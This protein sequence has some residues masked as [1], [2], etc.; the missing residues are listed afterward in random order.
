MSGVE[1]V[2]IFTSALSNQVEAYI[3]KSKW[4]LPS[5]PFQVNVINNPNSASVGDVMRELDQKTLIKSDFILVS[6][7][8][9]C[10]VPLQN[11]LEGHKER[12]SANKSFIMT[13]VLRKVAPGHRTQ[14]RGE[15]TVFVTGSDTSRV[16]HYEYLKHAPTT[17][18]LAIPRELV[19]TNDSLTFQNDLLDC[20]IDIV[21]PDVPPLFTEN[22]DWQHLRKDF[23]HGILMDELYGKTVHCHI[24]EADYSSRIES[25]STYD[26]VNMDVACRWAYPFC[27]DSN[28]VSG[29]TYKYSR[30]HIYKEKDVIL[31]RSAAVQESSIVGGGSIIGEGSV[32]IGSIIGMNCKIGRNVRLCYAKIWDDVVIEDNCQIG[33]SIVANNSHIGEGCTIASG[34]IVSFGVKL[35]KGSRIGKTERLTRFI[36]QD[37][38]VA[39]WPGKFMA[40]SYRDYED[41]EDEEEE[42][43]ETALTHRR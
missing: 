10:N 17:S 2:F 25:L 18:T 19:K 7:D 28:M 37:D 29:Q 23:L 38:S 32:V 20:F 6:G 26:A 14:P 41:S 30:G 8:I 3:E 39:V 1:E 13:S 33:N 31:A 27:P 16:L 43:I 42:L 36:E 35:E 9:V 5:S 12:K 22:F 15:N 24:L 11:I 4:A 21:S 40:D 34:A